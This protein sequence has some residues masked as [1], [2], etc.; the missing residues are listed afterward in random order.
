[1]RQAALLKGGRVDPAILH[2]EIAAL[3][4]RRDFLENSLNGQLDPNAK[5]DV[6]DIGSADIG[7][8]TRLAQ[9]SGWRLPGEA[10]GVKPDW[11]YY[12]HAQGGQGF[13]LI[14]KGDAPA[15]APPLRARKNGDVVTFETGRVPT[16]RNIATGLPPADVLAKLRAL[17]GWSGWVAAVEELRKLDHLK[18]TT[19]DLDQHALAAYAKLE[20]KAIKAGKEVDLDRLRSAAKAT[21]RKEVETAVRAIATGGTDKTSY[22]TVT[23]VLDHLDVSDR[24]NMMERWYHTRFAPTAEPHVP[25]HIETP[26]SSGGPASSKKRFADLIEGDT[27]IEVKDI[28]DT[29]DDDALGQLQDYIALVKRVEGKSNNGV[30]KLRY[31]FT[32]QEGGMRNLEILAERMAQPDLAGRISVEVFDKAGNRHIATTPTAAIELLAQLRK[33]TKP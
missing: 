7:A 31:V 23:K 15:D 26:A 32:K 6:I 18:H 1:M 33:P 24:G 27:A 29:L 25:H 5:V 14:R 8:S 30:K 4:H 16:V 20:A 28:V 11:Y 3:Q 21:S 9:Q 10:E 13:D 17:R 2:D 22:E 19:E 12:R